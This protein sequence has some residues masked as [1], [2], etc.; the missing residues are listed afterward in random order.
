M[1]EGLKIAERVYDEEVIIM[2]SIMNIITVDIFEYLI[3]SKHFS[4]YVSFINSNPHHSP[5]DKCSDRKL[6]QGEV[7]Y[8][9]RSHLA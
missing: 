1:G 6:R 7:K 9:S 3:G 4:E 2:S 5:T 8:Y